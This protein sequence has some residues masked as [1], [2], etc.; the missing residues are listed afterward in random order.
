ML[1]AAFFLGTAGSGKTSLVD[2]YSN[3]LNERNISCSTVNL[4]PAVLTLPYNP[5][6]DIRNFVDIAKLLR[7]RTLGPN[8]AIVA[9][10]DILATNLGD[11]L[12][13]LS[14]L[15]S[16]Y[17]L[18]DTPGQ[19]ELFAFREIGP[20]LV[21]RI[22]APQKASIF[23]LDPLILQSDT[24]VASLLL[25][26]A[27][28]S[29]RLRIPSL[30]VISKA[31][32]VGQSVLEELVERFENPDEFQKTI[33]HQNLSDY[34]ALRLIETVFEVSTPSIPLP[35]SVFD[36]ATLANLHAEVQRF[37]LG[38]SS[39]DVGQSQGAEDD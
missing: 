16:D 19:L 32:I 20:V 35:V 24:G 34:L 8:G 21:D 31:D 28:A 29:L 4:D 12:D 9:A 26:S 6:V 30:N 23:L 7:D 25:L 38:G 14:S 10:M 11:F 27:S 3:F 2:A 33:K 39:E 22:E 1:G 5:D 37:F 36:V 18:V 17:L 15:G 13:E